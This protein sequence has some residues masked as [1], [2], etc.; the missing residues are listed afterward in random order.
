MEAYILSFRRGGGGQ[1]EWYAILEIPSVN[2]A[3]KAAAFIGRKVV[4]KPKE[5]KVFTGRIVR[6]HGRRGRLLA[7]FKKPLPGQ[8]IGSKVKIL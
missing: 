5:D 2:T 8:A 4:W 3:G 7:R 1:K 6:T